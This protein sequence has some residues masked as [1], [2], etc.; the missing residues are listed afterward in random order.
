MKEDD[1]EVRTIYPEPEIR[2]RGVQLLPQPAPWPAR[3]GPDGQVAPALPREGTLTCSQKDIP[4]LASNWKDSPCP[5]RDTAG[6]RPVCSRLL[7]PGGCLGL[8]GCTQ[9]PIWPRRSQLTCCSPACTLSYP[10]APPRCHEQDT[11]SLQIQLLL[12]FQT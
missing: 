10:A 6:P 7:E 8:H 12:L 4:S 9:L 3:K 5:T 1:K 11:C 2:S